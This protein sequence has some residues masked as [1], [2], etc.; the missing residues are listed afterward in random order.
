MKWSLAILLLVWSLPAQAQIRPD[1][2]LPNNS[3]AT[4]NGNTIEI[5]GGTTAGSNLFHS[6]EQFNVRSGAIAHFQNA[7]AIDNIFSRITGNSPS[8]INGLIRANDTANLFLLNPNGILF[9]ENAALNIGGSLLATTADSINFADNTT[10]SATPSQVAPLLTVSIPIGLQFGPNSGAIVNRSVAETSQP[11]GTD[12][13]LVGLNVNP[14]ETLALIGGNVSLPGGELTAPGGQI[15]LCSVASNSQVRITPIVVGWRFG[16]EGVPEFG[17]IQLS[18]AADVDA[19]GEGGG[20]IRLQ[21]DPHLNHRRADVRSCGYLGKRKWRWHL[22]SGE[23]AFNSR[24]C[25]H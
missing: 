7:D 1:R 6:F 16:Y 18:D 14:N 17:D 5:T 24:W 21:G 15:E 8:R 10:F 19:S 12:D 2:T 22:H 3:I 25:R 13:S 9:G 23:S 11:L 4:Q 20:T